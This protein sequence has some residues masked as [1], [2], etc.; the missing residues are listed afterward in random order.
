M[1]KCTP[2]GCVVLAV[3]VDDI[4]LTGSD[5]AEVA[6]TKVYL[7]QHFVTHNLSPPQYVLGLE[8]AYMQDQM[9]LC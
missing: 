8:T 2:Q 5:E 6:T 3:Y 4:I 1:H 9:V 7:C